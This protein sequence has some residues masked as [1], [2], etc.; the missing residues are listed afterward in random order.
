MNKRFRFPTFRSVEGVQISININL[1]AEQFMNLPP[2][3]TKAIMKG[4]GQM[5]AIDAEMKAAQKKVQP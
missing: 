2:Q 3:T 4:I 1:S 5:V